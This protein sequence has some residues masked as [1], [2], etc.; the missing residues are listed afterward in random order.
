MLFNC[1]LWSIVLSCTTTSYCP[2]V[3]LCSKI[4]TEDCKSNFKRE[5][6]K[7]WNNITQSLEKRPKSNAMS[8][9]IWCNAT[10]FGSAVLFSEHN[11]TSPRFA[12]AERTTQRTVPQ[13]AD[14]MLFLIVD[15]LAIH[16][17]N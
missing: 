16:I 10:Q 12:I 1:V 2:V 9:K 17:K 11:Q 4:S 15:L 6:I 7:E 5:S 14:T 8:P 13:Y 3:A